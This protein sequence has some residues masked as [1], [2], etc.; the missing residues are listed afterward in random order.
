MTEN[1]K[2]P[3]MD[4]SSIDNTL[5]T[6]TVEIN[7]DTK[8]SEVF[9]SEQIFQSVVNLAENLSNEQYYIFG[10]SWIELALKEK[11]VK[12]T[13][14]HG[15]IDLAI[16]NVDSIK[17]LERAGCTL[18]EKK[19][20]RESKFF[21][22]IDKFGV[23]LEVM[24]REFDPED[25]LEIVVD[26]KTIIG[27]RLELEYLD[28]K[29]VIAMA[30]RNSTKVR[31]AILN[32]VNALEKTIDLD[33]LNMYIQKY[34]NEEKEKLI[35]QLQIGLE[36]KGITEYTNLINNQD[37]I[38]EGI[39]KKVLFVLEKISSDQT[40]Q[41]I[42]ESLDEIINEYSIYIIRNRYNLSESV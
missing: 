29:H 30:D 3:N 28:K 40:H 16:E 31:E 19:H 15:D 42:V 7:H 24:T 9:T 14:N 35:E 26:G 34:A 18:T 2:E 22:G 13:R 6:P 21:S 32:D 25:C 33:V 37:G 4:P 17:T 1:N 8:Q 39:K 41:Q 38:P 23:S 27:R 20:I 11:G 10:G 36:T 5:V 12:Y